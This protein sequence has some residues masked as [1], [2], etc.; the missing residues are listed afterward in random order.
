MCVM[1]LEN[2]IKMI[3]VD[4]DDTLLK[5]DKTISDDTLDVLKEA[6][7]RAIKLVFA[8]AR[9]DSAIR[10]MPEGLFDGY[11]LMNGAKAKIG[12]KLIY[13]R[14][15]EASIFAPFLTKLSQRGLKV[16]AK[17][18]GVHF[19]NFNVHEKWHDAGSFVIT[20][21][22]DVKEEAE[23]LYALIEKEDDWETVRQL[24]PE[25]TVLCPSRDH[26][27]MVT[28][29]EADKLHA[30][31]AVADFWGIPSRQIVAFGDDLNDKNMLAHVG[32][33][34]AMG[35]ARDE[36]RAVTDVCCGHNDEDGVARWL[37]E[38][39]LK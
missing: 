34:V 14:A 9:G 4:L 20:D 11:I 38:H 35:N 36:V 18:N 17:I 6:K 37:K 33:G 23:M 1:V 2:P 15:V 25:K 26:L 29:E 19:S 13:R 5:T 24:L 30:V 22:G 16:G 32:V 39:V 31:L 27:A 21:Y 7:R 3:V 28:H 8:T 10:L 12:D